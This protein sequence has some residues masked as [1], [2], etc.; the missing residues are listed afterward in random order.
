MNP[1]PQTRK[2]LASS[3]VYTAFLGITLGILV[4]AAAFVAFKCLA[5]YETLF[6]IPQ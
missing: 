5:Q 1:T 2:I 6:S 3:N 4:A